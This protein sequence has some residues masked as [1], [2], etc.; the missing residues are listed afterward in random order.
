M[1]SE[2][3]LTGQILTEAIDHVNVFNEKSKYFWLC[4][5]IWFEYLRREFDR[6]ED[7]GPVI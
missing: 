5:Q 1:F 6:E 4:A 3:S 7:Q 2:S